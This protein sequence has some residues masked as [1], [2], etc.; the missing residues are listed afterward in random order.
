MKRI[1]LAILS[2]LLSSTVAMSNPFV[3]CDPQA[4]VQ[5]YKVTGPAWVASPVTA[6]ADG[7]I[8]MDI[9]TSPVGTNSLTFAACKGDAIWGEACSAT[10]PFSFVR[11]A[12]V[13][14][15][16]LPANIR[17]TP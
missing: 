13:V 11:P 14:A 16:T 4:G 1:I 5:Y 7:S 9:A 10:V 3:V 2:I 6:Q 8:K 12:A 15:P 17:L